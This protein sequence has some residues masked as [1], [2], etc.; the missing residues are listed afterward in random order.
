MASEQHPSLYVVDSPEINAA[1]IGEER[2]FAYSGLSELP[3]DEMDAVFAHEMSHQQLLHPRRAAEAADASR[4]IGLVLAFLGGA[5][6][7][8]TSLI[9]G[10]VG[11]V[12]L[13]RYS[14]QQESEADRGALSVL[15]LEGYSD[16]G[17]LLIKTFEDLQ[18][19]VGDQKPSILQDH[20]AWPERIQRIRDLQ[21]MDS[22]H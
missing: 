16:P 19:R 11:N 14:R 15:R 2:F 1:S 21:S 10:G 17:E 22:K 5:E 12:T 18:R 8:G 4:F 3:R 13:P 6:S 7:E 9:V 20:P